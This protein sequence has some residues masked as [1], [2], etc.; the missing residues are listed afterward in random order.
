MQEIQLGV[1]GLGNMG[2]EHVRSLLAGSVPELRV[3]AAA[4]RRAERRAWARESLPAGTPIFE[5]GD[6]L[7][8]SA[9]VDAVLIATPHYQH[10]TLAVRAFGRG[11]HV[12]SEKPIGVFT[13]DA[14]RM[15]D[16][17]EASGKTFALMFNQRTNCVYRRLKA[18][19]D[20]GALGAV[21]RV[22]WTITDWYR[23]Q[24]YYD[25]GSWRATWAGEGGGVLLNQCPHQLD[26]LQWLFGLPTRVRAFCH[27]GKWHAI[28]VEDDVSAYL[29]FPNG[30][31][32]VFVTSTGDLPG[33]NRLE[34]TLERGRVVCDGKTIECYAIPVN[35]R[36]YCYTAD[37]AFT[38][39][40]AERSALETDGDNPQHTGVLRAFAAH[41]LRGEPLVAE[42][43]EGL[44]SL[45]LSNAMYLSAWTDCTIDMPMDEALFLRLLNERRERSTLKQS[46]DVTYNTDHSFGGRIVPEA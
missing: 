19:I 40:Q 14:R 21:K 2:S 34:I 28:E 38:D 7:I 45:L 17:A 26:L 31:T 42:G 4:D 23:T 32:G 6:A 39:I 44:N 9:D 20:D 11:L 15:I 43:A 33:V 18:L 27:V 3:A 29:E 5:E 37:C 30:A 1:I 8:D 13:L 36:E 16:A 35:E 41:I 46:P 25:S 12:L 10:P 24:R 22:S